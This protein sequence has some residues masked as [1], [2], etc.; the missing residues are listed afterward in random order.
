MRVIFLRHTYNFFFKNVDF[1]KV[2][3]CSGSVFSNTSTYMKMKCENCFAKTNFCLR[4]IIYSLSSIRIKSNCFFKPFNVFFKRNDVR[5]ST[6]QI[7]AD[8]GLK[9]EQ[10]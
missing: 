8:L 4:I 2:N 3:F 9:I 7:I 10:R 6:S 1:L 5:F